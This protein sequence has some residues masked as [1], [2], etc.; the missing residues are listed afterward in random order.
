MDF[1]KY[2][3]ERKAYNT[4]I[5]IEAPSTM[6]F[7]P[8]PTSPNLFGM[9]AKKH[10]SLNLTCVATVGCNDINYDIHFKTNT[11]DKYK[12]VLNVPDRAQCLVNY[13]AMSKFSKSIIIDRL[14]RNESY[15]QC[16]INYGTDLKTPS[17]QYMVFFPGYKIKLLNL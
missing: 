15:F 13:N 9:V 6:D 4:K 1:Q 14:T 16:E 3:L 5:V 8:L 7:V 2:D 17:A 11:T 10:Q 12:V